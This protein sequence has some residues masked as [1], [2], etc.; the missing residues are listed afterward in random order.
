MERETQR[1]RDRET[2]TE[3]ETMNELVFQS[4]LYME[5]KPPQENCGICF[6]RKCIG[7]HH[8]KMH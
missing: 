8:L 5:K 2:A 1:E 7:L 4:G 6:C 3:M